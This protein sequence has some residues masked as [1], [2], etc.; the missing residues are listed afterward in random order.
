MRPMN[1]IFKAGG[2]IY[3]EQLITNR[4]EVQRSMC[5]NIR[6]LPSSSIHGNSTTPGDL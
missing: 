4:Y 3:H 6:T 2:I 5:W 1:D